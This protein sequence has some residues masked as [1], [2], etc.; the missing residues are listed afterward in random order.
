MSETRELCF[1]FKFL[2]FVLLFT[3]TN[4]AIK[5][6]TGMNLTSTVTIYSKLNCLILR[7]NYYK[8]L[9]HIIENSDDIK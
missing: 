4:A 2:C 3:C 1:E 5:T 7:I 6:K 9:N 8:Y